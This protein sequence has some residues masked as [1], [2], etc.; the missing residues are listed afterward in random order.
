MKMTKREEDTTASPRIEL[1]DGEQTLTIEEI[2]YLLR[3]AEKIA[4]DAAGWA[5]LLDWGKRIEKMGL[6]PEEYG[7]VIDAFSAINRADFLPEN[8]R[9][10][11]FR[12]RPLPIGE[13]QT[14]SQ[15][16]LVAIMFA[17]AGIDRGHKVL[18]VGS[19][20]GIDSTSRPYRWPHR[21][22]NRSRETPQ[23]SKNGAR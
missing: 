22:S 11:A 14:I 17:V 19:G 21:I 3:E 10:H 13:G 7:L 1:F 20:T 12:D 6:N 9:S 8:M 2:E 4:A 5:D 16:S 15:P 23:V 18:E